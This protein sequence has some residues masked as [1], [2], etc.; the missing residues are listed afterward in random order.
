MSSRFLMITDIRL[1]MRP[2]SSGPNTTTA[3]VKTNGPAVA[4]K[5]VKRLEVA[6]RVEVAPSRFPVGRAILAGLMLAGAIIGHLT[7]ITPSST[8]AQLTQ[9]QF[10]ED[11]HALDDYGTF[12]QQRQEV[13]PEKVYR[14]LGAWN[15]DYYPPSLKLD[16]NLSVSLR[17]RDDARE[18]LTFLRGGEAYGMSLED[19]RM[20]RE[21]SSHPELGADLDNAGVALVLGVQ[22]RTSYYDRPMVGGIRVESAEKLRR[23][24]DYYLGSGNDLTAEQRGAIADIFKNARHWD[25]DLLQILDKL[26]A[27]E[28]VRFMHDASGDRDFTD[29]VSSRQ[30]LL[31]YGERLRGQVEL[32]HYQPSPERLQRLTDKPLRRVERALQITLAQ[33]EPLEG[34]ADVNQE[35]LQTNL[36]QFREAVQRLEQLRAQIAE[37]EG[38]GDNEELFKQFSE[39]QTH[40]L[41][42]GERLQR[43]SW[44]V[45]GRDRHDELRWGFG[46][47]GNM[48]NLVKKEAAP[49]GWTPH[50]QS[51]EDHRPAG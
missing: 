26:D 39:T 33:M 29:Y 21:L 6:D 27:G 31:Q 49:E 25:G 37:W 19:I 34:M 16:E 17:N 41:N 50:A 36:T 48:V 2:A 44:N 20:A 4:G 11:L 42:L 3:P 1:Y 32:D 40:V 46:E 24:H 22:G 8:I 43:V 35:A 45:F 51:L 15:D 18:L 10:L 23:V 14:K 9:D 28:K 47:L 12:Y 7:N 30:E 38:Q 5:P 13:S